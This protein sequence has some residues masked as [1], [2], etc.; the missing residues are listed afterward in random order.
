M[1]MEGWKEGNGK[2]GKR[3]EEERVM[4]RGKVGIG[5]EE[6][7]RWGTA[8]EAEW[9]GGKEGRW[10]RYS[11]LKVG[12]CVR[13]NLMTRPTRDIQLSYNGYCRQTV[14][15]SSEWVSKMHPRSNSTNYQ[16][17]SPPQ[18]NLLCIY[19]VRLHLA[20]TNTIQSNVHLV[21][22]ILQPDRTCRLDVFEEVHLPSTSFLEAILERVDG[23]RINRLSSWYDTIRD[24]ILTCARKPT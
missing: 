11:I 7:K 2:M 17:A 12:A 14:L 1:G 21:I 6:E 20:M 8:G 16:T 22:P 13:T 23:W 3:R 9:K 15:P 18:Q 5:N 10:R 4:W 24:A 19:L